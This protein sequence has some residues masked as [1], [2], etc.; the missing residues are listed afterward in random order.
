MQNTQLVSIIVP[1]YNRVDFIYETVESIIKQTYPNWEAI[2][3]D[4]GSTD[5]NFLAI[6]KLVQQDNR[7]KLLKRSKVA[8]GASVCRNIGLELAVGD[9]VMFLDS[10]DIL[11]PTCI[12]YRVKEM[13]ADPSLDFG[14]FQSLVFKDDLNGKKF[15]WNIDTDEDDL[16]RFLRKDALWQT[17]SPLY[18]RSSLIKIGGFDEQLLIWQDYELHTRAIYLDLKYKKFLDSAPD[19]FVRHHQQESISQKG[20]KRKEALLCREGI[21][22]GFINE[23]KNRNKLTSKHKD[24]LVS[25]FIVHCRGW[26]EAFNDLQ[27]AERLWVAVFEKQLL[28]KRDFYAINLY[29]KAYHNE[30]TNANVFNKLIRKAISL[31]MPSYFNKK[32]FLNK[33]PYKG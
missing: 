6:E 4:D 5:E 25:S 12:E 17:T 19:F 7:I 24:A 16:V 30:K 26:I 33:V 9:Y 3:V 18:R 11:S 8:K 31:M 23:L 10:D 32:T 2:M 1:T 15:L 28:N 21:L 13:A 14:V 22:F 27:N 20:F 29:L